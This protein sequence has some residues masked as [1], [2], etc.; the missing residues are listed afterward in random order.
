GDAG[1]VKL[2]RGDYIVFNTGTY[3]VWFTGYVTNDP[4]PQYIGSQ[5]T[6]PVFAYRYQA[7]SDDFLLNLSP[8][9][10]NLVFVNTTY[11]KIL[12]QLANTLQPGVF[13]TTGI[14]DGPTVGQYI[15]DPTKAFSD[16][17]KEF[18]QSTMYL[19]SA[20]NHHLFFAPID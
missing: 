11:G 12:A 14:N 5:G 9:G 17:V 19:F 18:T 15:V 2:T 6:T 3:G 4:E 16:I 7:F 20:K 10:L 8:I 1:F 13:D